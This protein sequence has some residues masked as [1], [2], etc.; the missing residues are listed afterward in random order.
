M[1]I[2]KLFKTVIGLLNLHKHYNTN[3]SFANA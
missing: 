3:L 1:V 2:A